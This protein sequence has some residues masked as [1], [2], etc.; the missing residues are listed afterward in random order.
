M[1]TNSSSPLPRSDYLNVAALSRL[2]N[3]VQNSYKFL[4]FL[5]LLDV[6]QG[7][8]FNVEVPISFQSLIVEMLVYAW[9]PHTYFKLSFGKQD[10]IAQKLTSLSPNIAQLEKAVTSRQQVR[11]VI[12]SQNVTDVV[13]HFRRYVPFR[14]LKPFVEQE[15]EPNIASKGNDLERVM[16]GL[17][18]EYFESLKPLYRFDSTELKN[19][20]SIIIHPDWASYLNQHQ[21]ILR[22]WASWKWLEYMQ[23]KN[24]STPA[25]ASKLFM[26]TKRNSLKNQ[27]D[28][29]RQIMK[30]SELRCIYSQQ[31][32]DPNNISLDHYIPWSFVAHDQLWNLIPTSAVV[33]SSKSNKIP[34]DKYFDDFVRLQ[35][36]G[37]VTTHTALTES[38]WLN[39]I[40]PFISDLGISE[41][42]DLRDI[43]KLMN[44]YENTI[45]PLVLLAK[46]Q[47]FG[48]D[49]QYN[50]AV[51]DGS[52]IGII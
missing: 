34:S 6:L 19:C 11:R 50:N 37:L 17:V 29:W 15:L 28:Y 14:L 7:K 4:F 27:T 21:G 38:E 12:T 46:N 49:W 51:N 39:E 10:Q 1:S 52:S 48:T 40:E 43:E 45:K 8:H 9:Y 3:D 5:S 36:T 18:N 33:N 47:G 35:H 31:L 30:D 26:P 23:K 16:P 2:F 32:I 20:Q 41:K 44:A 25:I 13:S 24:P 22:G 42:D